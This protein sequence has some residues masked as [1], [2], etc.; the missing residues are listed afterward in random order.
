[1]LK[2]IR[3]SLLLSI[4]LSLTACGTINPQEYASTLDTRSPL[5]E[6]AECQQ[7]RKMA[8]NFE[9]RD[10][11]RGGAGV[12]A[13]VVVGVIAAPIMGVIETDATRKKQ[14]VVNRLKHDCEG[15]VIVDATDPDRKTVLPTR[16]AASVKRADEQAATADIRASRALPVQERLA[17]LDDL[18]AKKLIT[19]AEYN[20][21]RRA[22]LSGL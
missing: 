3:R 19:D 22:I 11:A 10:L 4:V 6:T 8:K 7:A 15:V 5:Y 9:D 2:V 17:R 20:Q 14:S 16:Q 13:G 12:A 21:Q 1:M 18:R